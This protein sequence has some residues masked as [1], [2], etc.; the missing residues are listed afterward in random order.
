MISSQE[1]NFVAFHIDIDDKVLREAQSVAK[2]VNNAETE[3]QLELMFSSVKKFYPKASLYI[4]V[5]YTHLTL[6]TTPYV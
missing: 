3:N 4:S 1:I 6:P 2:A 5:S